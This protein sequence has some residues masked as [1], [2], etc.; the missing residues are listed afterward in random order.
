MM[1]RRQLL[2]AAVPALLGAAAGMTARTEPVAAADQFGSSDFRQVWQRDEAGQSGFWGNLSDAS[3]GF[4]EMSYD[5][6]SGKRLVQYFPAGRMEQTIPGGAV[7]S[8]LLV[9][10]MV[11]GDV[12]LGGGRSQHLGANPTRV[13]GNANSENPDFPFPTFADLAL[14]PR[15]AVPG[16]TALI[17]VMVTGH[18]WVDTA[19]PT[20]R[21]VVQGFLNIGGFGDTV[22]DFTG[23]YQ[24][25]LW[26]GFQEDVIN[27]ALGAKIAESTGFPITP[28]FLTQAGGDNVIVQAFERRILAQLF[29]SDG[30]DPLYYV[31]KTG[32][33]YANWRY[34]SK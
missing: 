20:F 9:K 29:P 19:D 27:T 11:S 22:R 32:T 28:A 12:L 6:A 13:I 23:T 21:E 15:F 17:F 7:T 14:L 8:G 30:S 31:V 4:Q 26:R 18:K 10:E 5:A 16:K 34:P 2:V 33:M 3:D 1:R 25:T 24:Q